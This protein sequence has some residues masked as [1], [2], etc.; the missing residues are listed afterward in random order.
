MSKIVDFFRPNGWGF[1]LTLALLITVLLVLLLDFSLKKFTHHGD[2]V[3]M[4]NYVG[5]CYTDLMNSASE[6][7]TFEVSRVKIFDESKP[8]G[9]VVKQEPL[10]GEN[11]KHGRKVTLTVTTATPRTV[12]MPQLAGNITLRQARHILEDSGL[13]VGTVVETESDSPGLVLQQYSEKTGK[14]IAAGTDI[15]QGEKIKLEVGV[16]RRNPVD[17]GSDGDAFDDTEVAPQVDGV[18]VAPQMEF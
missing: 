6:D 15:K 11:V 10:P 12:K 13:E 7:F 17:S 16:P 4:P 14:V 5:K 18:D 1:H 8:D 3:K 9:T 2:E